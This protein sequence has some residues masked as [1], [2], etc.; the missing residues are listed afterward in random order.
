MNTNPFIIKSDSSGSP[1]R[2]LDF[3]SGF[4]DESWLQELLR[5]FPGILPTSEIEPIFYPLVSI[6]REVTTNV[7]AIDNLFISQHG[8]PVLV[9]TKLWKNREAKRE[10]IAQAIDYASSMSKWNYQKLNE[11]TKEYTNKYMQKEVEL[12]DYVQ[13]QC[14]PIREGRDYF[15]EIVSKNL[16]LGR[17][18]TLIVGDKIR[19][20][21]KEMLNYSANRY[22]HLST[23]IALI[24]LKFYHLH[25]NEDWPLLVIP[26]IETKTEIVERSIVQIHLHKDGDYEIN[27]H[28]EKADSKQ[29]RKRV[30]LTEEAFWELL[31]K[32]NADVYKKTYD[33]VEYFREKDGITIDPAES[34]LVVRFNIQNSGQQVSLFFITTKAELCVWSNS[35]TEQLRR[36][37]IPLAVVEEY[38]E[39]MRNILFMDKNRVEFAAAV[40]KIDIERFTDT[41][42]A[43]CDDL[44]DAE[45]DV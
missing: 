40:Q 28:Q 31:Q 2:A 35:I 32:R 23:D 27:V 39:K 11:V 5:L 20:S 33:L 21:M 37:G 44:Q 22:P 3:K 16:R 13:N 38:I 15:E 10:V 18:L 24:Q 26:R 42:D 4:Y 17:F 6:G 7:G 34:A 43:F 25:G 9:E 45:I 8:Y 19:Q 14:G 30:T 29:T 12:F 1:L 41:V 36:V